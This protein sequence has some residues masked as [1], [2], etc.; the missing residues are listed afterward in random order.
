MCSKQNVLLGT[1][2]F[3]WSSPFFGCT[4]HTK[5]GGANFPPPKNGG[6]VCT[7][8]MFGVWADRAVGAE[9]PPGLLAIEDVKPDEYYQA[10]DQVREALSDLSEQLQQNADSRLA[11]W[12][13]FHRRVSVQVVDGL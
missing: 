13:H 7:S 2:T 12:V 8:K 9:A 3:A 11:E 5:I 6:E 1:S 4:S 10:S